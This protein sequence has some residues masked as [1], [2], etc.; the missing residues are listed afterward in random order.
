EVLESEGDAVLRLFQAL[1]AREKSLDF[2]L[3]VEQWRKLNEAF[4]QLKTAIHRHYS[5]DGNA[6]AHRGGM[7]AF[8]LAMV[9]SVW[10]AW[11]EGADLSSEEVLTCSDDAF[12]AALSL[13]LYYAQCSGHILRAMGST[14]RPEMP[15]ED[16]LLF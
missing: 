7:H 16:R 10:Q 3:T 6:V 2:R 11:E 5:Y 14:G 15:T 4:Q 9:L 12:D 13:A 8:R 1:E